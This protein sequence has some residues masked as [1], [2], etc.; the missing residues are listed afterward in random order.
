MILQ[1]Y[2]EAKLDL[3]FIYEADLIMTFDITVFVQQN[4]PISL[5]GGWGIFLEAQQVWL[6]LV[7]L[8]GQF[9]GE[10]VVQNGIELVR[11]R[12]LGGLCT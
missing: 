4:L 3:L 9:M 12:P 8:T 10:N 2:A 5:I 11:H 6:N 1:S 7:Y